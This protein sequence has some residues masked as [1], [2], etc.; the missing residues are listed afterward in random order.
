MLVLVGLVKSLALLR[1]V[2]AMSVPTFTLDASRTATKPGVRMPALLLGSGPPGTTPASGDCWQFPGSA[3]AKYYNKTY[4]DCGNVSVVST[5][6]WISMGGTGID[7]ASTYLD[8]TGIALGLRQSGVARTDIFITSKVGPYWP[9]G[10]DDT[11]TQF[12]TIQEDFGDREFVVDLL[13]IHWPSGGGKSADPDCRPGGNA[14]SCRIS[15]W[16]A[17]LHILATGGARAVGTFHYTAA[18]TAVQVC[19]YQYQYH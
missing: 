15:T 5:R 2:A 17:M 19:K 11:L 12:K 13:L 8:E 3:S 6:T 4:D 9:L 18:R 14:T 10:Y 16:K 1:S 7:T